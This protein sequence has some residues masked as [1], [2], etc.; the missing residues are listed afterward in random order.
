MKKQTYPLKELGIEKALERS[1][2]A[3]A[4]IAIVKRLQQRKH[5]AY[6]VGGAVRDLM[7][8]IEPKD[9]DVATDASPEDIRKIFRRSARII[10]R[11][12]RLVHVRQ[13]HSVVEVS[14]FRRRTPKSETETV[15]GL[16]A[17]NTYGNAEED[18]QRRDLTINALMLDP[19]HRIV[20][21]HLGAK[22]DIDD[23]LLRVIGDPPT[24]YAEDPVRMIRV[25]RL[26]A[27]L[28]C[29]IDPAA[30]RPIARSAKLLD[31][32][33]PSRLFDEL[34]KTVN[35]GAAY[36]TFE[37]MRKH[38][39]LGATLPGIEEFDRKQ[40][41]YMRDALRANDEQFQQG[42]RNSLSVLIACIYWSRVAEQWRQ[43]CADGEGVIDLIEELLANSGLEGNKVITRFVK[44]HVR[45][46]WEYQYRF[47]KI[48][49]EGRAFRFNPDSYNVTKALCLFKLRIKHGEIPREE[50]TKLE[51]AFA[52]RPAQPRTRPRRP[53]RRGGRRSRRPAADE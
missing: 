52:S 41:D 33:S 34:K 20:V 5:E 2:H 15:G 48:V 12:F 29:D 53:R 44:T 42:E 39:I 40:L 13:G 49:T 27:K 23:R 14:T 19:T 46:I 30:E 47:H 28:R 51:D 32:I 43:A 37:L 4:S 8:G 3:Q 36:K 31:V 9:Y 7:L 25:L 26:A 10:G 11:R 35:S 21:D 38:K 1:E 24:R 17:D 45:N 50:Q 18:A 6:I 16:Q 22:K